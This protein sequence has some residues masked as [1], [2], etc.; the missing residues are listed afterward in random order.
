[1]LESS[2]PTNRASAPRFDALADPDFFL[3]QEF[4]GAGIGQRFLVQ[5]L[6]FALEIGLPTSRKAD[7][8]PSIE[9]YDAGGDP[10]KKATIVCDE[11]ERAA[12]SQKRWSAGAAGAI[13]AAAV[14]IDSVRAGGSAFSGRKQRLKPLDRD[15]IE[16][17]CGFIEQED[18]GFRGECLGECDALFLAAR[19]AADSQVGIEPES[20]DRALC[21]GVQSPAVRG[22]KLGLQC[23]HA[24]E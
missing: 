18:I 20:I 16:V 14:C 6:F 23:L 21:C 5:H 19:E 22:L 9:F 1:M 3:R 12:G 8:M 4:V 10:L 7:E 24:F 2:N 13:A 17:V 11:E 15:N